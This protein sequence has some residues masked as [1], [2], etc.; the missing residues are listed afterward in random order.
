M[1][2]A[3][4]RDLYGTTPNGRVSSAPYW[5]ATKFGT[6]LPLSLLPNFSS[7]RPLTSASNLFGDVGRKPFGIWALWWLLLGV[8]TRTHTAYLARHSKVLESKAVRQ[9]HR[10][11]HLPLPTNGLVRCPG[12][13][14][15]NSLA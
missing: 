6:F 11:G 10:S 4:S 7:D 5:R 15:W 8:R 12:I 3:T 2:H 9:I 1:G 14:H 13:R